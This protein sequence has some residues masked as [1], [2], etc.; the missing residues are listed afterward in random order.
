MIKS[1]KSKAHFLYC[2]FLLRFTTPF[3]NSKTIY[4]IFFSQKKNIKYWTIIFRD[5]Y[6]RVSIR[7]SQREEELSQRE[8]ELQLRKQ[9]I[10]QL[11]ME[12][13]ELEE[14]GR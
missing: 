12:Y 3:A 4:P 14:F 6:K 2:Y 10:K 9:E 11:E 5:K 8:H 1:C 13:K 7:L